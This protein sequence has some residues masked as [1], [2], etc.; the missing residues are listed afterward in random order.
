[1]RPALLLI[2][3][4]ASSLILPLPEE[5]LENWISLRSLRG[6]YYLFWGGN[7]VLI[8]KMILKMTNYAS[9][10]LWRNAYSPALEDEEES[11][12]RVFCFNHVRKSPRLT[13]ITEPSISAQMER[14]VDILWFMQIKINRAEVICSL[15][16][17]M[18]TCE[19]LNTSAA[20]CT[21]TT[22]D[23]EGSEPQWSLVT[24]L[25]Q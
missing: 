2:T 21:T 7:L 22:K 18:N 19:A 15:R 6:W 14:F 5:R 20:V 23:I 3:M 13:W 1:M 10:Q 8:I 25:Y 12:R 16:S 11:P 17:H 9:F 4:C 24:K